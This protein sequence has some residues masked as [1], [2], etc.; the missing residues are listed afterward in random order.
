MGRSDGQEC[1]EEWRVLSI[2]SGRGLCGV[3]FQLAM[4]LGRKAGFDGKL[5][6]LEAYPTG[7]GW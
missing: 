3:S 1:T 4:N 2:V 7:P 5:E 6:A